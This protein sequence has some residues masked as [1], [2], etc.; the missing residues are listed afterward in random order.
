MNQHRTEN[1]LCDIYIK[2]TKTSDVLQIEV[3]ANIK[4]SRHFLQKATEL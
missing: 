2:A 3:N 1:L 4:F